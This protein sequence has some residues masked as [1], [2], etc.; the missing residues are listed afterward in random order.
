MPKKMLVIVIA[1]V[2]TAGAVSFV[3][4]RT[5]L[6][7]PPAGSPVPRVINYDGVLEQNGQPM[8]GTYDFRFQLIDGLDEVVWPIAGSTVLYAERSLEVKDGK[9]GVKFPDIQANPGE[10]DLPDKVFDTKPLKLKISVRASGGTQ[11]FTLSP[12][13]VINAVPFAV[14]SEQAVANGVPVGMIGIFSDNCPLGWE[15]VSELDGAFIRGGDSFAGPAGADSATVAFSSM[16]T[17]G[18]VD[19]NNPYASGTDSCQRGCPDGYTLQWL[20]FSQCVFD[21]GGCRTHSHTV[22][23][24]QT[25]ST[26]PKYYT[27][28][29]CR[30]KGFSP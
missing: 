8:T 14:K 12:A 20:H 26:V 23:F 10:V 4:A 30:Y 18:P 15:R 11:F 5:V 13:I 3:L 7:A 17:S 6:P 19:S 2:L 28:L 9:F 27:A 24:S 22:S 25:I 1:A 29:F 16:G 21:A